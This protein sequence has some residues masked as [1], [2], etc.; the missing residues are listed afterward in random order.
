MKAQRM[1]NSAYDV[2]KKNMSGDEADETP[3]GTALFKFEV[4]V[5]NVAMERIK[6]KI[7]TFYLRH[8]DMCADFSC[9]NPN[10]FFLTNTRRCFA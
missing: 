3:S 7:E 5:Y 10:N 4:E 6:I 8:E 1:V 9:L 2:L